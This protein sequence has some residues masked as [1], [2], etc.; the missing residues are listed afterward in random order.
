MKNAHSPDKVRCASASA[1][2]QTLVTLFVSR[3]MGIVVQDEQRMTSA[4]LNLLGID[5]PYFIIRKTSTFDSVSCF[6]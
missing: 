1:A 3:E 4:Y 5:V 6:K 2:F